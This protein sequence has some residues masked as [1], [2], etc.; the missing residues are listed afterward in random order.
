M[1]YGAE[2]VPE[3]FLWTACTV[4]LLFIIITHWLTRDKKDSTATGD[5]VIGSKGSYT[6][7]PIIV[8]TKRVEIIDLKANYVGYIKREFDNF[9]QMLLSFVLPNYFVDFYSENTNGD[10][11]IS[12]HKLREKKDLLQSRWAVKVFSKDD[13]EETF[14]INSDRKMMSNNILS[15]PYKNEIIN[16]TKDGNSS[17]YFHQSGTQISHIS[18]YGKL[19]PRHVFIDNQDDALPILLLACIYEIIKCYK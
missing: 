17:I 4:F 19:P 15:F 9:F 8:M 3:W 13:G 14:M 12:I 11:K 5:G 18:S 7:N 10:L 16:V 1:T 6:E 2:S